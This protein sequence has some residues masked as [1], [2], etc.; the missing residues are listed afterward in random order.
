MIP[1]QRCWIRLSFAQA[2]RDIWEVTL[3]GCEGA[4]AGRLVTWTERLNAEDAEEV[5]KRLPSGSSKQ[6]AGSDDFSSVEERRE[7][8]LTSEEA[9]RL[10]AMLKNWEAIKKGFPE[11]DWN[12]ARTRPGREERWAGQLMIDETST[13]LEIQ[14]GDHTDEITWG[15][16]PAQG[17]EALNEVVDQVRGLTE[18]PPG[19]REWQ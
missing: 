19:L 9:E 4:F 11:S 18:G 5:V 2:Y 3:D 16:W 14:I 1:R 10:W 7:R 15:S 12:R 6:R 8:A 13:T 17:W